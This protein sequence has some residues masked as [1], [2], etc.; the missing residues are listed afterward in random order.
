VVFPPFHIPAVPFTLETLQIIFPYA[1]M[2]AAVGLIESL[3]TL[4][5][6]DQITESR[7]DSNREC[8]A[9]GGGNML[10]GLFF[11]MGGCAMLG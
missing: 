11:G 9:Q 5:L 7:G 8:L 1:A 4:N 10:S 3:L 6:I 2:V